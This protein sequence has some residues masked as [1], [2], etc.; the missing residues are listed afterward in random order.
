VLIQDAK[1]AFPQEGTQPEQDKS[2]MCADDTLIPAVNKDNA[3]M[4][5]RGASNRLNRCTIRNSTWDI[6]RASDTM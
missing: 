2:A 1:A 3:E 6:G 4:C 5:M